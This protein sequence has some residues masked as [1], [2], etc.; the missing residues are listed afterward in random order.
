MPSVARLSFVQLS[1]GRLQKS[2]VA[3]AS[4]MPGVSYI[5]T[6]IVTGNQ[7]IKKEGEA[8]QLQNPEKH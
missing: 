2:L 6:Q 7:K 5:I 3:D 4:V 1:S 8:Y